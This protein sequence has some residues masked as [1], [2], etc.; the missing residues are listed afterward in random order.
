MSQ[1]Q[2]EPIL[3]PS[4]ALGPGVTPA[5]KRVQQAATQSSIRPQ[6][7]GRGAQ[8]GQHDPLLR[9]RTRCL[10]SGPCIRAAMLPVPS[11]ATPSPGLKSSLHCRGCWVPTRTQ[12][13]QALGA[14]SLQDQSLSRDKGLPS[15]R[16][17]CLL[18]LS[19]F[20]FFI[21]LFAISWGHSLGIWRFPG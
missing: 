4:V 6:H 7:P 14:P 19:P 16:S 2:R 9:P 8:P 15:C 3:M 12:L 11:T 17:S 1:L 10:L 21:Y 13:T 20:F 5:S 18:S